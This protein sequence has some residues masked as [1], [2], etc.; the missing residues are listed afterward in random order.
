MKKSVFI[1]IDGYIVL[2]Q[3][4]REKTKFQAV[5]ITVCWKAVIS[6]KTIKEERTKNMYNNDNYRLNFVEQRSLLYL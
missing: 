2:Q 6:E 3:E 4:K 1:I 5:S